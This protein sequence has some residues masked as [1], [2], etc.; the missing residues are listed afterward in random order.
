MG[1]SG[2]RVVAALPCPGCRR[3]VRVV[4]R[5]TPNQGWG[6]QQ[7]LWFTCTKCSPTRIHIDARIEG[8]PSDTSFLEANWKWL[9][10]KALTSERRR[11]RRELAVRRRAESLLKQ[12]LNGRQRRS[13]ESQRLVRVPSRRVPG[14]RYE[15]NE[16]QVG[17][18]ATALLDPKVRA[19]FSPPGLSVSV[20]RKH[21]RGLSVARIPLCLHPTGALPPPDQ[22]LAL[23][24]LLDADEASA[25]KKGSRM[26]RGLP[27]ERIA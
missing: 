10:S 25:W 5:P 22:T 1:G 16:T 26:L 27:P 2:G 23:K 8:L 14:L 19:T 20:I 21:R 4:H 11:R 6:H 17:A 13:Y 18:H 7:T 9:A 3:E 12:Y 24:L 15:I